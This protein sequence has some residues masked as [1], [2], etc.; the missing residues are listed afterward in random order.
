MFFKKILIKTNKSITDYPYDGYDGG[1]GNGGRSGGPRGGG[2]G[3]DVI[4][5]VFTLH[6]HFCVCIFFFIFLLFC[7]K[8]NKIFIIFFSFMILLVGGVAFD[9]NYPFCPSKKNDWIFVNCSFYKY[10]CFF[11]PANLKFQTKLFIDQ[12]KNLSPSMTLL[13]ALLFFYFKKKFKKKNQVQ[14]QFI[15]T[16]FFYLRFRW[17]WRWKLSR[18]KTKRR[19]WTSTKASALLNIEYFSFF[20]KSVW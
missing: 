11:V 20:L 16:I 5:F 2:K 1:Y 7:R 14:S 4:C 12:K 8:R 15:L 18:R 17:H 9:K 3:I 19:W 10:F 6:H 13:F